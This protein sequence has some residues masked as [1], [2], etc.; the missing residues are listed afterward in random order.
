MPKVSS[1]TPQVGN[2]HRFN[3]YLDDKFAFGA[4]EDL[5]VNFRLIPGKVIAEADLEQILFEAQID[6]AEV[7]TIPEHFSS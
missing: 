4:D 3:I 1:I 2:P 5:V 6:T 7:S